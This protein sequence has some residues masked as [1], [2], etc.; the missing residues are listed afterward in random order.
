MYQHN[1]HKEE[2]IQLRGIT[3]DLPLWNQEVEIPKIQHPDWLWSG[4]DI[5]AEV[6]NKMK[7]KFADDSL[8]Y[9]KALIILGG[10]ATDHEI[11]SY[12]ND[13]ENW[14]LSIVSARRNYFKDAPFYIVSSYPGK[15]KM[16][17]KG[18]PNTIWFINYKNLLTLTL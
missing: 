12:F 18:S 17:P 15:K 1:L 9:L 6:Y 8:A 7:S 2:M 14:P 4:N 10:Q 11:K 13:E 16:G 3:A 5:K